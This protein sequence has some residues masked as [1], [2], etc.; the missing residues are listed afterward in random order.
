MFKNLTEYQKLYI[1]TVLWMTFGGVALLNF[2]SHNTVGAN[3][4]LAITGAVGIYKTLE[5]VR[6]ARDLEELKEDSDVS[7]H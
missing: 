7:V 1:Q 5:L 4:C 2:S 6:V 3:F